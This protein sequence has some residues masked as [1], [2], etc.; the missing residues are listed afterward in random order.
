MRV[1]VVSSSNRTTRRVVLRRST[2]PCLLSRERNA[3]VG[4]SETTVCSTVSASP[5]T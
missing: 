3:Q 1:S 5:V 4:Q 2:W